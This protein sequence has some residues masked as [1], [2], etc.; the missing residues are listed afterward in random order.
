MTTIENGILLNDVDTKSNFSTMTDEEILAELKCSPDF[1]KFVFPNAW[2]S[3]FSLP[4]KTC[5]NPKEFIKESP[6]LKRTQHTY[7]S[8]KIEEIEA[9]PGGNRPLL[10]V[11]SFEVKVVPTNQIADE[12]PVE[13]PE[14]LA[15]S[16]EATETTLPPS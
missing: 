15:C 9:K 13:T 5:Q 3:K 12:C 4:E 10:E 1:D 7:V 16:T 14:L 6:W 8:S 11:P 2:Y